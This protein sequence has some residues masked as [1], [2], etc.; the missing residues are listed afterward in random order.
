MPRSPSRG[1]R[2]SRALL[3][4]LSAAVLTAPIASG[5]APSDTATTDTLYRTVA[6]LDSTLFD[7]YNRCDLATIG[8][9]V[10]SDLEFYHDQTGL[11]RGRAALLDALRQNICGKVRRDLVPGTLQVYPLRHYGAVEIGEHR[12]CDPRRYT[13]C[14]EE[15]GAAKFVHIW[16]R[17]DGTWQLTRVISYDHASSDQSER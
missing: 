8:G 14:G 6:A 15:S 9:L 3:L 1:H 2:V 4:L 7:A 13:H 11:A 12:F 17:L 5:Q 10:A 16:Q